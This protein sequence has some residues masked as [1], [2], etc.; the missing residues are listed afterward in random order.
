M[1]LVDT[2]VIAAWID[3]D[4]RHHRECEKALLHW[5]DQDDLAISALTYAELAAARRSKEALDE[6]LAGFIRIDFDFDAAFRA[7]QAFGRWNPGKRKKPVLPDFL[8][9][10]Q[11]SVLGLRHLTNDRHQIQAFPEVDFLFP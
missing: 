11:A 6:I 10:G 7:G 9:R 5:A 3:P 1:I 4:H 2:S 8:I